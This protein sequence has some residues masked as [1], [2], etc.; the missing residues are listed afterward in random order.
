MLDAAHAWQRIVD[1]LGATAD[2][3]A[4]L[5]EALVTVANGTVTPDAKAAFDRARGLAP[6]DPRARFYLALALSQSGDKAGAAAAWRALIADAPKD[7]PWLPTANAELAKLS[8]PDANDV[9]ASASMTPAERQQMIEGMVA[10]LATK[11]KSAPRRSRWLGAT[12]TF[13]YG[14]GPRRRRAR[15][16]LRGAGGACRRRRRSSA[17]VEAAA[18]D[19]GVT[20]GNAMTR[21][22]AA[23]DPDRCCG[24]W[25]SVA[26][27]RARPL[28]AVGPHRL[29]QFA[30]RHCREAESRPG[31]GSGCGGLVVAGSLIEAG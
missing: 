12:H 21:K 1:L 6:D 2:R 14:A 20:E 3:E 7:A 30:E 24:G 22:A 10:S 15:R 27:G 8:G 17:A 23:P 25:C 28:R 13:L 31:H 19:A 4:N 26:A 16:A 9:P 5:G 29:L 18:R 11:L